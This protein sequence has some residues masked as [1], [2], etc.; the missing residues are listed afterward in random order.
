MSELVQYIQGY[1]GIK[2]E[3]IAKLTPLFQE[4]MLKKGEYFI[5]KGQ[6]CRNL[7][8]IRSGQ[9]RVFNFDGEK[10]I[11]QWI[12]TQGEFATDLSSMVFDTPARWN[13]QALSDCELFN[14]SKEKYRKIGEFV[15]NWDYL[16]KL[17]IAK[18][19]LTLEDRVYSFLSMSAEERYKALFEQKKELF[20]TTQQYY[21]ASMLG[22]SPETLSRIRKKS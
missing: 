9:L 18:C 5:Q 11:T 12:S 10:E 15:E 7:S 16:E 8:F 20:N 17:F 2:E 4:T 3:N 21:L 22:M 19:F 1:F 13:I 14:I 6:Q